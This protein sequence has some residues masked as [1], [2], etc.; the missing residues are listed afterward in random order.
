MIERKKI[1]IFFIMIL[2][3]FLV[4][5]VTIFKKI[6][7]QYFG[8][9]NVWIETPT[10]LIRHKVISKISNNARDEVDMR[11]PEFK[12]VKFSLKVNAKDVFLIGDFNKWSAVNPMNKRSGNNWELEIPLVRGRYKYLFLIDGREILDPLNPDTDYYNDKKVSVIEVK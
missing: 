4:I 7:S 1:L 11:L 3:V 5:P 2:F 10:L 8:F 12:F 9:I 6:L